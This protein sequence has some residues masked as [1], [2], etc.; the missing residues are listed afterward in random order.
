MASN[1]S[2]LIRREGGILIATLNR[3]EKMNAINKDFLDGLK[4]LL[5]VLDSDKA[6]RVVILTASGDKA[7][8]VGADLKER[9]GMN[10]KDVLTRMDFVRLLYPRIEKMGV[11][12]I[13]AVNGMALGGGLELALT[14]DL[15]VASESAT[16][17]FPEVDL[18]IIPGNGGT[19]RLS[20]V[21]G[22]A[23]AMELIFLAKKLTANEALALGLVN[24]VAPV[25]Q[26]LPYAIKMATK[27]LEAGPK[28][29]RMAKMAIRGGIE[30]SME[31]GLQY[32]L[33]CYKSVLYSKD[34]TEGLKAFAEKR[35]PVYTGD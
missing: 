3:P 13:C 24:Q 5:D 17:G 7:F 6:V 27:M 14:C 31:H 29:L 21:V 32:E 25:G 9:A 19:Q 26:A 18:A 10:E 33:D 30:R 8:C 34:R 23:K 12:F 28:A 4:E 11:P 15:R 35:K 22:L 1:D 2:L 20:R 16:F